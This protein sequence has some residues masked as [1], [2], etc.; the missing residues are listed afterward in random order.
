MFPPHLAYFG[1]P[2]LAYGH[3]KR[4][5]TL[6]VSANVYICKAERTLI[7]AKRDVNKLFSAS[8]SLICDPLT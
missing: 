2:Y 1:P 6:L 7:Y 3:L 8:P 5:L 4:M